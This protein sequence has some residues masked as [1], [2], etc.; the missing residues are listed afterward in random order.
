MD[1]VRRVL[2]ATYMKDSLRMENLM[3]KGVYK[4]IKEFTKVLGQQVLGK[5][6]VSGLQQQE[7]NMKGNGKEIGRMVLVNL[8]GLM[9]VG[10]KE[11]SEIFLSSE[12]VK[13]NSR[14]GTIMKENMS[15]GNL[16]VS[17]FISGRMELYIVANFKLV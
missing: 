8:N 9:E 2:M 7:I 5:V 13:N 1:L 16:M 14:M 6:M 17:E 10:I 12:R 4:P 11:S 15:M 3:E